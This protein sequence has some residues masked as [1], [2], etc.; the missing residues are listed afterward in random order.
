MSLFC[1]SPVGLER[2]RSLGSLSAASVGS[3]G[4]QSTGLFSFSD[5]PSHARD[6]VRSLI[7]SVYSASFGQALLHSIQSIHSV[8]FSRFRELSV[9]FTFIG[10]ILSHFPHEMHFSLSHVILT[11]EK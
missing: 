5:S 7:Y 4:K 6:S 3:S 2:V 9:T 1:S 8:P 11:S 10:H